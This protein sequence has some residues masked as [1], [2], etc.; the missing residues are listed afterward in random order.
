MK[1]LTKSIFR[2]NNDKSRKFSRSKP[3]G[4]SRLL[5]V[6]IVLGLV[7]TVLSPVSAAITPVPQS[8]ATIKVAV[9]Q[10][11][12]GS[13]VQDN[14]QKIASFMSQASL[15][16]CRLIVFPEGVL[17]PVKDPSDPS[18][19]TFLQ[20]VEAEAANDRI[21]VLLGILSVSST[22]K[23]FNWMVVINPQGQEIHR[24]P[25]LYDNPTGELPHIFHIDDIPCSA[26]L[27]ADRW[28]RGVTELPIIEG[29]QISFELSH[30][31]RSEWVPALE[32]YWCV[33]RALRHNVYVVFANTAANGNDGD[34]CGHSA[35][36]DPSGQFV[37]R[38]FGDQEQM[39]TAYLDMTKSTGR[40]AGLRRNHRAFAKFWE[41]GQQIRDGQTLSIAQ[42]SRYTSPTINVRIAVAQMG[43]TRAK[44]TNVGRMEQ[45]VSQAKANL[46]DVVVFPALA[47]TGG[48]KSDIKNFTQSDASK[49]LARIQNAA[50][51]YAV[52]VIFGMP[53][54]AGTL[55]MNTAY[56]I[57]PDGSVVTRYDQM[58]VDWPDVF[59]A[60]SCPSQ[61][62][63]K[64][65]GVPAVVTVGKDKLWSEIAEMSAY[66]GVQL[67][68]NLAYDPE[69]GPDEDL[70]QLQVAS[71]FASFFTFSA[72]ANA[73][74][75]TGLTNPSA[76]GSGGSVLWDDLTGYQEMQAAVKHTSWPQAS[77]YQIYSSFSANCIVRAGKGDEILYAT[78]KVNQSNSF[79]EDSKNTRMRPW[80]WYGAQ[81]VT[82][83]F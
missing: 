64:L 66:A 20:A 59:A 55:R 26:V 57:G 19:I 38:T 75:S 83:C 39:L 11:G 6:V 9:A 63:F 67:L 24:Y 34:N 69:G 42:W 1:S 76:S 68:F 32:W 65:N 56:V 3:S 78:R 72:V 52:Y 40:E 2:S 58:A 18:T 27:C 82:S 81:T 51:Q 77:S 29:A 30:N 70:R 35:V 36:V 49:Y 54:I 47:V 44:L 8:S 53:R 5:A 12:F 14:L 71:N 10:M 13:T 16:G 23:Q 62:W 22:G 50:K 33:P 46:A 45:L 80:Y 25:K 15:A 28:L 17:R 73:A 37:T 31:F 4:V 43:L 60:G 7:W 21:Y 79:K 48:V 41:V 61:M 74:S